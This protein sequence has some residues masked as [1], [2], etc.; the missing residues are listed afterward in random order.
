MQ[1]GYVGK[2]LRVDLTS[3]VITLEDLPTEHILRKYIGGVGLGVKFL[4][5]ELNRETEPLSPNNRLIFMTGPMTGTKYPCSSDTSLVTLNFNTGY[6]VGS[7][8][9]HGLFGAYLKF[10][11]YDG[12]IIQGAAKKPAYLW[13]C[14]DE[15]E[16]RDAGNLW[17]K[18]TDESVDLVKAQIGTHKV[19]VA[20]IGPAGENLVHGSAIDID[21]YHMFCKAGVGA[22]MGSKN[23]KA[24][25]IKGNGK[26]PVADPGELSK[27]TG[28]WYDMAFKDGR[29]PTLHKAGITRLYEV[30][31]GRN[32]FSAHK[33]LLSPASG[34][35]WTRRMVEGWKEFKITP[36]ACWSCPV[37]CK[38]R[39]EITSGP[40]KGHVA[41]LGG[42]G[43]SHEG[44][45]GIVGIM[46]PGTV[47]YL[48]DLNDRLGV[49]SSELGCC[50]GLAF[51]L[52]ER[53]LLTKEQTDGL[54]LKWGNAEAAEALLRKIVNREG[55]GKIFAEGPKK[56]AER[57]GGDAPKYVIHIKGAGHNMHDWRP[58]WGLMLGQVTA[59]AGPCW[60]HGFANEM[61]PEQDLGYLERNPPFKT[62]GLAEAVAK[63]SLKA[64]WQDSWGGCFIGSLLGFPGA[65]FLPIRAVAA[66]TGWRDFSFDESMDVGHRIITLERIFNMKRGLT[67]ENDLDIGPRLLDPPADGAAKGKSIAPYLRDLIMEFYECM[68][69]DKETG[70]PTQQ[71]LEKL[72]LMEAARG[73]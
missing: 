63:S 26:V 27:I 61:L 6:T 70:R 23:L 18:Y 51:E 59:G 53:G 43:E 15:V 37:A 52:Y 24:I 40:H 38:Y 72:D 39:S 57:L 60:Q 48:T 9:S 41:T 71:T 34:L 47:H 49:D 29:S 32:Y 7:S 36:K 64:L 16:I 21:H 31:V 54:E 2:V 69:W 20:A 25:A 14:D 68:G 30:V 33:N 67:I 13:I 22:I 46:D 1:G 65:A 5:D 8:H 42:G 55:F 4:N 66:T 73:L 10:A 56:A 45:A 50:L 12:L 28:D 62:E 44:S 11:G 35:E 19:S 17:G 3:G 58:A